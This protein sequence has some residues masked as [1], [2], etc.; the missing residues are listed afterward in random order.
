MRRDARRQ[1][2]GYSELILRMARENPR[3]GCLRIRG[4]LLKLCVRV[5]ATK[6]RFLIRDRDT[7]FSGPFDEASAPRRKGDRD[8][9]PGPASER[10]RRAVGPHGPDGVSGLDPGTRPA[11]LGASPSHLHF[12]LQR[13]KAASRSGPEDA[14]VASRSV[15][16]VAGR[17]RRRDVLG[18]LIHEYELAAEH[19]RRFVRPSVPKRYDRV[20]RRGIT[21]WRRAWT[22]LDPIWDRMGR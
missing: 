4:E 20:I 6:I 16:P 12:S 13:P 10:L 17:V 18:G 21:G 11:P 2:R 5:S 15:P 9:G 8:P 3:W 19:D 7:M 1:P 22:E 14:A